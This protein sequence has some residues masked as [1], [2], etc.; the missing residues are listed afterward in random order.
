MKLAGALLISAL[1]VFPALSAMRVFRSFMAVTVCS[2]VISVI[3]AISGMLVSILAGTP[4]GSTV[5]AA[6][7]IMFAG[8]FIAGKILGRR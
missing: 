8:F 6:D 2:A 3:C 7:M 4:V 5:A 1:V